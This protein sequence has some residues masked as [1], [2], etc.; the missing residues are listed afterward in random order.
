M[1]SVLNDKVAKGFIIAP[2]YFR[3]SQGTA[4]KKKNNDKVAVHIMSPCLR[5]IKKCLRCFLL[6]VT[7]SWV[8]IIL[9]G[10]FFFFFDRRIFDW[11]AKDFKKKCFTEVAEKVKMTLSSLSQVIRLTFQLPHPKPLDE[12]LSILQVF[13]VFAGKPFDSSFLIIRKQSKFIG[14]Y[15][16][17]IMINLG[18]FYSGKKLD[19]RQRYDF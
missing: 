6:L 18:S 3:D 19:S 14:A 2:A 13:D 7:V 16:H 4:T 9:I 1:V 15:N 5:L 8:V 11:L 12:F 17:M 10:E